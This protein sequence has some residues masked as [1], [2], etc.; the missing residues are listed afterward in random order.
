MWEAFVFCLEC[1]WTKA[2]DSVILS[3]SRSVGL[4]ENVLNAMN[5]LG[6]TDATCVGWLNTLT[7][8]ALMFIY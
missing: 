5:D 4:G 2:S 6:P 8:Y 1:L 3:M 7:C